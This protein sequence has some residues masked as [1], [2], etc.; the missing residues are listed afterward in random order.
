V[1]LLLAIATGLPDLAREL[2]DY[3]EYEYHD[4]GP[5]PLAETVEGFETMAAEQ[6]EDWLA[7][8]E[9]FKTLDIPDLRSWITLIRRFSFH[10][11]R[12]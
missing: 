2:F 11:D 5:F 4:N 6:F 12:V 10:L 3:I 1:I 7:T 8:H 9:D